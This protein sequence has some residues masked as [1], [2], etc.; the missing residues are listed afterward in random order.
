MNVTPRP[1]R[2]FQQGHG[3]VFSAWCWSMIPIYIITAARFVREGQWADLAF[4]PLWLWVSMPPGR[5]AW[6]ASCQHPHTH[7]Y[8]V[9]IH[10]AQ[11]AGA[12]TSLCP[13]PCVPYCSVSAGTLADA[14]AH[15]IYGS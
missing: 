4:T 10:L 2:F 5:P 9:L 3:W 1:C 15:P 11:H 8:H 12:T 14:T 6:T 7:S 13:H